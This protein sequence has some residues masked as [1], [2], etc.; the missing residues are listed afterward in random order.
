MFKPSL[1]LF[2]LALIYVLFL[3]FFSFWV[4]ARNRLF[5][6]KRTGLFIFFFALFLRFLPAFVFPFAS[7]YDISYFR[8]A[9]EKIV[10]GEDIYYN[11]D[12]RHYFAFL[13]TFAFIV[14]FFLKLEKELNISFLF[15][16]KLP[17][18]LADALIAFLIFK[19]SRNFKSA[20]LYSISPLPIIVGA[21]S[22]QFDSLTL[23]FVLGALFLFSQ[24]KYFWGYFSLGLATLFKPWAVLF[25]P[26]TFFKPEVK[27]RI[28][29]VLAFCAPIL[30]ILFF[31][32]LKVTKPNFFNLFL[33]IPMYDSGLG[34]WGPSFILSFFLPNRWLHFLA[35]SAKIWVVGLI[36]LVSRFA[37]SKKVFLLAKWVI[38]LIYIFALGI[39][40]HYLFWLLPFVLLTADSFLK[41]Y[42]FW[43]GSYYILFAVLGGLDF[44]FVPP[45]SPLFL[46]KIFLVWLWLFFAVWGLKEIREILRRYLYSSS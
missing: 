11:L 2:V 25:S 9:G 20:L 3:H 35:N 10:Q 46:E 14:S 31:Y 30:V 37:K 32:A 44:N 40:R 24:K 39:S 1:F 16:E 15:L 42:L 45:S 12:V 8:W 38:L 22:G 21:Y 26:I 34:W 33:L 13:P 27:K 23:F 43:V 18:I 36:L 17:I 41:P 28:L 19:I 4:A 7:G 5:L 29:L 6:V